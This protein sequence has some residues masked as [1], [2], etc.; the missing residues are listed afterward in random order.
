MN[1]EKETSERGLDYIKKCEGKGKP[2][3]PFI[4]YLCRARVPTIGYGHT[5]GV[6]H[7][8]VI[9]GRK[10]TEAQADAYL[11]KDVAKWEYY[12]E[13]YTKREITQEQYDC[14]VS[15]CHNC[16]PGA[17]KKICHYLNKYGPAAVPQRIL[18]YNKYRKK[19]GGPLLYS[20]GL[21]N[22]RIEEV[23]MWN[24]APITIER[25]AEPAPLPQSVEQDQ[26]EPLKIVTKSRTFLAALVSI[27]STV[28]SYIF[29]TASEVANVA[30]EKLTL[31]NTLY[32]MAGDNLKTILF[33]TAIGAGIA[34][35]LIRGDA[36][37]EKKIA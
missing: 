33:I 1:E 6:T 13:L 35:I 28:F 20:Q 18:L 7:Q 24:E 31:W 11:K 17:L 10:I 22:R 37:K 29:N 32:S 2:G 34:I 25:P 30:Q 15:F 9:D 3:R 21:M 26:G 5:K 4:A 12:V 19:K 36:E 27:I 16:G 8:D 23:A 14:L